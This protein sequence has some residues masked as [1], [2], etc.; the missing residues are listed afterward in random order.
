MPLTKSNGLRTAVKLGE[1]TEEEAL[2]SLR[3]V[4][5]T[6]AFISDT[7]VSWLRRRIKRRK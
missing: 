4:E 1:L 6:G 5:A 7:I 3:Q 2:E